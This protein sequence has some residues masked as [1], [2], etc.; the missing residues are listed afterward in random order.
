M[1]GINEMCLINGGGAHK[2]VAKYQR[3]NSMKNSVA[4]VLYRSSIGISGVA[5]RQWQNGVKSTN[6]RRK[7]S[8]TNVFGHHISPQRSS[9]DVS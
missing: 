4:G 5:Y 8:S 6:N 9:I 2:R 3:Q 1:A 7:A